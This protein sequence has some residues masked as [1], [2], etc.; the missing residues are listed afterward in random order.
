MRT[1]ILQFSNFS[2]SFTELHSLS[3]NV[4]ALM[5]GLQVLKCFLLV[6]KLVHQTILH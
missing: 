5:A 3:V 2:F 6:Y 4:S 1:D